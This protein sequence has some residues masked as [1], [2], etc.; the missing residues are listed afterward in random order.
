[1]EKI[2]FSRRR[3]R[4]NA[5]QITYASLFNKDIEYSNLID[6]LKFVIND[7][8]KRNDEFAI[9]LYKRYVENYLLI[10]ALITTSMKNKWNMDYMP[11]VS[12]SILKIAI[13][14]FLDQSVNSSVIINEY[15]EISK[16][17]GSA[18]DFK[19]IHAILGAILEV[20]RKN[21]ANFKV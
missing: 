8:E 10:D 1:M 5:I 6:N 12:Q 20:L 2:N 7:L 15:I 11:Y 9:L 16:E 14:E 3:S 17:Y 19:Y 18:D 13:S 4:I 21:V